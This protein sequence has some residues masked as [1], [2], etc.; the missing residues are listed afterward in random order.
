MT[1][2][3]ER[4]RKSGRLVRWHLLSRGRRE[5]R[6]DVEETDLDGQLG[7]VEAGAGPGPVLGGELEVALPGP[8]GQDAEKVAQVGLGSWR[9]AAHLVQ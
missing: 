4:R 6:R 7:G 3:S 2:T 5:R 9:A 1:A 8:V